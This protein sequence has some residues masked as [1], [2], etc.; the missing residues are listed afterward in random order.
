MGVFD[1][2]LKLSKLPTRLQ[3]KPEYKVYLYTGTPSTSQTTA[4]SSVQYTASA[5]VTSTK[6][7]VI[8]KKEGSAIEFGG[9]KY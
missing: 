5:H 1:G 4:P 2:E 6:T 9:L 7:T 3:N 8:P